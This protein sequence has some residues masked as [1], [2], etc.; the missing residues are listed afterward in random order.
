[1]DKTDSSHWRYY[2]IVLISCLI[3]LGVI[4]AIV[5]VSHNNKSTNID[6]TIDQR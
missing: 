6:I 5:A 4:A 2:K 1:M 3:T